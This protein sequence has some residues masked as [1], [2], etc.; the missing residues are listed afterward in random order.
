MLFFQGLVDS[1]VDFT[2]QEVELPATLW[3]YPVI[4]YMPSP[5]A[6]VTQKAKDDLASALAVCSLVHLTLAELNSV[7]GDGKPVISCFP[8]GV[9]RWYH[10]LLRLCHQLDCSDSTRCSF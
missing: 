4:G 7:H 3:V 2:A 1:W 10:L 5:G 6:G 8:Y 9:S